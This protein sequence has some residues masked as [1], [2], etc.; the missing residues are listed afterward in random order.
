MQYSL[1]TVFFPMILEL[2]HIGTQISS[3]SYGSID[4]S[5]YITDF[6]LISVPFSGL[7]GCLSLLPVIAEF[8]GLADVHVREVIPYFTYSSDLLYVLYY[9]A[10]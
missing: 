5:E 8:L 7:G 3:D 2:R 4:K 9:L 6:L 1:L 10:V